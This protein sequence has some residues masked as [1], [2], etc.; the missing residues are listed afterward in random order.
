[1]AS[2][3]RESDEGFTMSDAEGSR[4]VK[5]EFEKLDSAYSEVQ[6]FALATEQETQLLLEQLGDKRAQFV[7]MPTRIPT[8]GGYITS[9]Y[10]V[11]LSPYDNRRKLHEGIDIANRFGADIIAPADGVVSFAGVKPG[12]GRVVILDHRN[13]IET[14]YAHG[15]R[16]YVNAGA[17][18]HRGQRLAAVGNTGHSTGPH[19]HYEIRVSG[20]TVD[21]CGYILDSACVGRTTRMISRG[22]PPEGVEPGLVDPD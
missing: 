20:L 16:L 7:G 13:G 15:S 12:Y 4:F 14:L 5:T 18:V 11:R 10:G 17:I 8:L 2:L 1:M 9:E 19:V 6:R 22:R 21:P 3:M